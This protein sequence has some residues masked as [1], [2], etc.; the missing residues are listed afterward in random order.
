MWRELLRDVR[1]RRALSLA[2]DR[3]EINQ[4]IYFGLGLPSNN[5]V[6]PHSPLYKP[7]YSTT[8]ATTD[9]EQANR[10]L[11]EIG[12]SKRGDDG[13]RLLPDGR[14][15]MIIV[16]TAGESTEE[17]DVLELIR[18]TWKKIGIELFTKPSQ[19]EVFRNRI[20]A[21]ETMMS[22][23]T[24][25][26]NGFPSADMSPRSSPRPASSSCSGRNGASSTRPPASPARR[27]TCRR[28]SS[29]STC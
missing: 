13:M 3:D 7:E 17:T 4:V 23:W 24:G 12:L 8:W 28:R 5:T 10:L 25:I 16:E 20:F 29:C 22:V 26:E 15:M 2:I 14:P 6:L 9:I 1:F 11:D 18:D 27:P 21:G 19:R